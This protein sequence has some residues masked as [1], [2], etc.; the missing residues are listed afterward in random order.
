[1]AW[2]CSGRSNADLIKNM[3][4]AGLIKSQRVAEAMQKVDRANY[5][6]PQFRSDAYNDSPQSIGFNVTIS[7][8]HMHAHAA[9]L[10]LPYLL[11]ESSVLDIG[12]GSGYLLSVLHH[13]TKS[14]ARAG[15]VV[16]VEHIPELAMISMSNIR[17]DGLAE[18][19][20]S[21]RIVVAETD[22]RMGEPRFAPY[23]AIHVGAAATEIPE[24]L[25]EQLDQPGRLIIPVDN[26]SGSYQSL[27]QVDKDVDGAV[28]RKKLFNVMYVPLTNLA[29][30]LES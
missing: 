19:L 1:M 3:Q 27:W 21:N 8:P 17:S 5:V 30:Q 9:E 28:Q 13:L 2:R 7:A 20:D 15:H 12:S 18:E 10:L 22:G 11:P 23:S 6:L 16:G 26:N 14:N 29:Q 24:M 25:V 4:N